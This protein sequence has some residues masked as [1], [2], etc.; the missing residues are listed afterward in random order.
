VS[1]ASLESAN[2][3]KGDSGQISVEGG[4]KALLSAHT[5]SVLSDLTQGGRGGRI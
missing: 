5:K 2:A 1:R 4:G 3:G